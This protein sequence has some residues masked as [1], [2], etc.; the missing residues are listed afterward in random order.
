MQTVTMSGA[1]FTATLETSE[2]LK[3]NDFPPVTW[4]RK[5]KGSQAVWT[6]TNAQRDALVA[7]VTLL[8]ECSA[9]WGL[10]DPET[11]AD[12]TAMRAFLRQQKVP[13][14]SLRG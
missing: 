7:H 8:Y 13:I 4:R 10:G 6:V 1:C 9:G 11:H 14:W 5:G 12:R 2:F 3:E